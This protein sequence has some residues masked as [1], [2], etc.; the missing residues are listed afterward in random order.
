MTT[1]FR[2]TNRFP[3]DDLFSRRRFLYISTE[4]NRFHDDDFSDDIFPQRR[5]FSRHDNQCDDIFPQ[6]RTVFRTDHFRPRL[7]NRTRLPDYT[8]CVTSTCVM[9]PTHR[10]IKVQR[11]QAIMRR[12][13]FFRSRIPCHRFI[14]L[15]S[16]PGHG[17]FY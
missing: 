7:N 17:C 3:C 9:R 11:S 8:R 14:I 12:S 6:R 16:N 5:P 13:V 2:V 4:T 15:P 10:L 1:I